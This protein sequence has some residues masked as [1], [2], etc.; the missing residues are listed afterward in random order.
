MADRVLHI[1]WHL[2]LRRTDLRVFRL[3]GAAALEFAKGVG[4]EGNPRAAAPQRHKGVRYGVMRR[5]T[6]RY[7]GI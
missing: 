2:R 7:G 1:G 4:S 5:D 3:R 6:T